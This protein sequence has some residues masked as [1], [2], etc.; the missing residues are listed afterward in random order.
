MGFRHCG[1]E[2][3]LSS[4]SPCFPETPALSF[5]SDSHEQAGQKGPGINSLIYKDTAKT[6]RIKRL[7]QDYEGRNGT[8]PDPESP[9]FSSVLLAPKDLGGIFLFRNSFDLGMEAHFSNYR[10]GGQGGSI[11]RRS[12]LLQDETLSPKKR[13]MN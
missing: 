10:T 5:C 1:L 2:N 3:P 12:R 11:V 13:E 7:T 8:E 9:F 4:C 6:P